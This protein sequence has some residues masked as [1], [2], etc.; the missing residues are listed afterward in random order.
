MLLPS[1]RHDTGA[2][3]RQSSSADEGSKNVPEPD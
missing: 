3:L 2:N 1:C